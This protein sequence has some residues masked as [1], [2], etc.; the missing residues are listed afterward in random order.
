MATDLRTRVAVVAAIATVTVLS[1]IS[2]LGFVAAVDAAHQSQ[3][4]TLNAQIDQLEAEWA[5]EDSPRTSRF[6]SGLSLR[7]VRAGEPI[8]G[9]SPS[10]LQVV[11]ESDRPGIQAIVGEVS[12]RQMDEAFAAVR[13]GL[14]ISVAVLGLLVGV[15]AWI[16]VD[17][18]LKPVR[19]LTR[20]ARAIE[21]D[22]SLEL[23]PVEGSGDE[24][25]ELAD[26]FNTMLQKLRATDSERRRFVSDASHELR[27]PLMVLAADAEF[28]LDHG[29]D[30][31]ELA[32]SVHTQSERLTALVDDLLT[33]A[34]IDEGHIVEAS[35]L[36]VAQVLA[37]AHAEAIATASPDVLQLDIADVSSALANV[38]ANA[39]R[40][41]ASDVRIAVDA[42]AG[43]VTFT[44]DDDGPGI[45]AAERGDVFKRFYRPDMGRRRNEGGAGLG[46]AI[47]KAEVNKFDGTISVDDSPLGGARFVL[48]VPIVG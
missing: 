30:P 42:A 27:T 32:A 25:A 13:T 20:R 12:T 5:A 34:S 8:P 29:G 35:P 24:I 44:V 9:E 11:R 1:V 15:T 48:V 21:A 4:D 43:E 26:T 14:W 38:V 2:A 7:I 3:L 47:A 10:A 31:R 22:P 17:R 33:L 41:K 45:P 16:V 23:L 36:T 6:E 28:A 46:L 37:A 40:Y 39:N 18:A 19:S